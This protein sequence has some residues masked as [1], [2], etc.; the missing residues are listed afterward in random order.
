LLFRISHQHLLTLKAFFPF[1]GCWRRNDFQAA[2]K[3]STFCRVITVSMSFRVLLFSVLFGCLNIA[4]PAQMVT[5]D[6]GFSSG[7]R[8]LSGIIDQPAVGEA[9]ALIVF[10]HGSGATNIRADNSYSDLRRRFVDLG[11]ACVVWDKPGAGRSEGVF[12][13]NQPLEESAREVLEAAA[14]LRK[15]HVPGSQKIGLWSTS[16][17][18]WVAPLALAR[19]PDIGFWISVSGVPA[20]DNKYYLLASNLP[21]EGRTPEQTRRLLEEWKRG[22]QIFMSG[23]DYQTYLAATENL[24]RDPAVKYFA[25]DLTSSARDYQTE[26]SGY[27]KAKESFPFDEATLSLIRVPNFATLLSGLN[28]DVLALFGEKDTNVDWRRARALYETTLGRNPKATLVVHTFPDAN[29]ALAISRTGSVREVEGVSLSAGVKS[30]GYYA[31]QIE[32][33][34]K[35]VVSNGEGSPPK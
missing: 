31:T 28:V 11:I 24:R 19:D 12:D 14:Y 17:G 32:W 34:R 23:G 27:L 3:H 33:L 10:I 18:C 1:A 13:S 2:E 30:A 22:R 25:G 4:L 29:H 6:F 26:Q 21:L 35:F 9:R 8:L 15:A 5:R 7:G 20:E 16:A